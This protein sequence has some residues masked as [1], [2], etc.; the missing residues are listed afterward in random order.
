MA[1]RSR[2]QLEY[3]LGTLDIK[4]DQC[5]DLGGSQLPIKSRVASWDVREY[6]IAD[7][8]Q[9]HETKQ[10]P[11]YI[12]DIDKEPPPEALKMRFNMVFCLEV[13]EYVI[14]P[15]KVLIR[16]NAVMKEGGVLYI[17]F[18]FCYPHHNPAGRDYLRYTR[19]GAERLIKE[20]GF[21]VEDIFIR[22]GSDL[23]V[24]TYQA[25]GMRGT[26]GYD[27]TEVAYVFKCIKKWIE[28]K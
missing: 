25:E 2:Q 17:S 26:K 5:L 27:H 20:S 7:L 4:A 15:L 16:L 22:S 28:K 12:W 6:V 8:E 24:K 3:Y 1:S 23:L 19:W 11:D 18:P 21:E 14:E 9:P 10:P 13:M